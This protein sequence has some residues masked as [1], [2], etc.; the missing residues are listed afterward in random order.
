MIKDFYE[1]FHPIVESVLKI[2]ERP[3]IERILGIDPKSGKQ[4]I[5][6]MGRFGP[7]IQIGNP[8]DKNEKPK[9]AKLNKDQRLE[10]ITLEEALKLFELPKNIGIFEN[11]EVVVA[12]GKFGPYL[13]HKSN[14]YSL[15]KTDDPMN[16][17]L[18]RAIEIINEKKEKENKKVI[19][20]FTYNKKEIQILNGRYGAYISIDKKN[21]RIPKNKDPETLTLKDC[22]D[23]IDAKK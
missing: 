4:V 21:Y 18:E 5:A 11:E 14:F 9:F 8:D 23:I 2:S 20:T 10:T 1:H 7:M 3:N 22:L 17:N 12:I 15:S 16:I 19:N 13:R 6:R